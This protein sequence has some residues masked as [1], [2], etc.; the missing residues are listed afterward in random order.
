MRAAVSAVLRSGSLPMSSAT[1]ESMI[2]SELR[3]MFC[4][5]WSERRI[6]VTTIALSSAL[7]VWLVAL[8]WPGLAW[9]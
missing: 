7:A 4:D 3:R 9:A 5:D 8:A 2:W 1:T 6:P